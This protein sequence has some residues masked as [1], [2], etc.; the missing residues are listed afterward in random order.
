MKWKIFT[1]SFSCIHTLFFSSDETFSWIAKPLI[2]KSL[3]SYLD[4]TL[5]AFQI[6]GISIGSL[7]DI[8]SGPIT[9]FFKSIRN[10]LDFDFEEDN[11]GLF[12]W[13][14]F[15]LLNLLKLYL[16]FSFFKSAYTQ[17]LVSCSDDANRKLKKKL[18]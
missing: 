14:I 9:T 17:V 13:C 18:K 15:F 5:F 8:P 16:F 3:K 7:D 1:F 11:E 6:D 4:F 12:Y 10:T 2:L